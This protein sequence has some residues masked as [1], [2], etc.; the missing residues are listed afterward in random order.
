[1]K[2]RELIEL[3]QKC[4]PED[5]VFYDAGNGFE[6][7][8]LQVLCFDPEN[9]G[10]DMDIFGVDDVLIGSGTLRGH[11]YLTEDKLEAET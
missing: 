7:N 6:N 2:V 1:M 4:N 5:I 8:D 11:V 9:H 10:E 3:L